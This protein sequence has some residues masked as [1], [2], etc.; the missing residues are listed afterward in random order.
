MFK[1]NKTDV[2]KVDNFFPSMKDFFN[3]GNGILLTFLQICISES[4]S[5]LG[6]YMIFKNSLNSY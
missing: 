1:L 5:N 6:L 2:S 3:R 4:L